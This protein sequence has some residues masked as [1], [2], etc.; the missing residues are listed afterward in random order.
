METIA[1]FWRS[2]VCQLNSAVRLNLTMTGARRTPSQVDLQAGTEQDWGFLMISLLLLLVLAWGF[3]IGYR[4][5]L[6]LQ[7]YYL[8]SP[9]HRLFMPGPVLQNLKNN[10]IVLPYAN[11]RKVRELSFSH[12]ISSFQ[13]DKVFYAGIGYLLVFGS[14]LY[15]RSFAWS[16]FTLDSK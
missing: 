1:L 2:T 4:R 11:P 3:Y 14:C 15:H 13:L 12:R 7:V 6:V 9:W 16:P 8:I 5:G 10:S